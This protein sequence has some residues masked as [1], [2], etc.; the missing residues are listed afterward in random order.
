MIRGGEKNTSKGVI[1]NNIHTMSMMKRNVFIAL[2]AEIARPVFVTS[3]FSM[4]P[5]SCRKIGSNV[6]GSASNSPLLI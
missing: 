3:L 4:C 6:S 5:I 2:M 1:I